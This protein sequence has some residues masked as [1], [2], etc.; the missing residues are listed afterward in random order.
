MSI[1]L[2]QIDRSKIA[3]CGP[4]WNP[5]RGCIKVSPGCKNCYMYRDKKRYGQDP[6]TPVRS[7]VQTF[8]KP[9]KWQ[10][11]VREGKRVGH[12]RL[13]FTCSWSDW[14]IKESDPWRG[15]AWSIVRQCPD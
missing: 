7:A 15:D 8:N 5:W 9:L 11:E 12:D 4:T 3:W 1:E 6:Y 2:S 10:R 13:V 14:F